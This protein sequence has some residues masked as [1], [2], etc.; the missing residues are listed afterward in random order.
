MNS[1]LV[2]VIIPMYNAEKYI[3][4]TVESII[5]QTYRNWEVVIVDDCSTDFSCKIVER[6][7]KVN[8]RIK[9]IKLNINFGGPAYPRNIGLDNITGDFIAFL[10]A[11]DVWEKD[12]L[13]LQVEFML[14][15]DILIS[16]TL[17]SKIDKDGKII[18]KQ[19]V[20][21]EEYSIFQIDQ[22]LDKNR[23]SLSSVMI[24]R[25]FC[26]NKIRFRED[27]ILIAAEDYFFWL[28]FLY[29]NKVDAYVINKPLLKYRVF[30]TSLSR[31]GALLR[32]R[33]REYLPRFIFIYE[34]DYYKS[35]WNLAY[36]TFI[37][38]AKVYVKYKLCKIKITCKY[39]EKDN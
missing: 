9:L 11:D 28:E 32:N 21:T 30:N 6:F 5:A 23:L 35:F 8:S 39:V 29:I 36:K 22:F 12:K 15:N 7:K 13:E 18:D 10:D 14:K 4:E 38:F 31:K 17:N 3:E 25:E 33:I 34:F 19:D 27:K 37:E 1:P 16:G 24:K 26:K 20:K 2:S